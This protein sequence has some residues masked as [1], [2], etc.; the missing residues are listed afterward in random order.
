V[1]YDIMWRPV[2]EVKTDANPN[3][4]LTASPQEVIRSRDFN[5]VPFLLGSNSHEGSFFLIRECKIKYG[6]H[7]GYSIHVN[8]KL[9]LTL[10]KHHATKTY[11]G[12]WWY[13]S[14]HS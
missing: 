9:S 10:T 14:T 6:M 12:E 3:P 2:A 7:M 11:W 5:R 8:V 4:F 13:S 1:Q